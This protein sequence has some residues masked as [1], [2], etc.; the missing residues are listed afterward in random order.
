MTVTRKTV[1]DAIPN[2]K[3]SLAGNVQEPLIKGLIPAKKFA[4]TV[5]TLAFTVAMMETLSVQ[6][7]AIPPVKLSLAGFAPGVHPLAKT[8]A[9]ISV[10]MA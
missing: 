6:M 5:L 7:D 10:A 4:V 3:L 9:P 2:A 8:R 1:M